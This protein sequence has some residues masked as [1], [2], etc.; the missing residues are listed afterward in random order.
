M[1]FLKRIPPVLTFAIGLLAAAASIVG[2]FFPDFPVWAA[3]GGVLTLIVVT[4]QYSATGPAVV[5]FSEVDWRAHGEGYRFATGTRHGKGRQPVVSVYMPLPAGGYE[6]VVCDV[7]T[8]DSGEIVLSA[9]K[10]FAGQV[11]IM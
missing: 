8:L 4:M 9:S 5:S 10:P 7:H 1:S 3:S 6:E 11:R 2:A